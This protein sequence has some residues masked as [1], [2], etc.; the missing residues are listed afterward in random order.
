MRCSQEEVSKQMLKIGWFTSMSK[1]KDY[2]RLHVGIHVFHLYTLSTG[3]YHISTKILWISTIPLWFLKPGRYSK[4]RGSR[5]WRLE[6][7]KSTCGLETQ[8]WGFSP[9]NVWAKTMMIFWHVM[10]EGDSTHRD[11]SDI[12]KIIQFWVVIVELWIFEVMCG[13]IC[14]GEHVG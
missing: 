12:L 14:Q 6:C 11:K 8:A 5:V 4:P 2:T 7:H 3:F 1:G 9:I 13:L 10:D